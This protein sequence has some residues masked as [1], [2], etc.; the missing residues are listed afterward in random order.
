[1]LLECP[2]MRIN[3]SIQNAP[4]ILNISFDGIE[5]ET[6]V[7]EAD[8]RGYAISSGA[9]CSSEKRKPSRTLEALNVPEEATKGTVRISFGRHNTVDATADL[10]SLVLETVK[11]LRKMRLYAQN[12]T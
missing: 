7:L 10:A 12:A 3:E 6:L 9:A 5:G 8:A 1:M 2:H 11:R 4:H